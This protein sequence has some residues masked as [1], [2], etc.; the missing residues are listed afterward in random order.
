MYIVKTNPLG[1]TIWTRSYGGSLIDKGNVVI[2]TSD[3]NFVIAGLRNTTTDSTQAYVIKLTSNGILLWDSLYGGIGNEEFNGL[4]EIENDGGYALN[5]STTT[6]VNGD[7]DFYLIKV[8]KD[9]NKQ[10]EYSYG[11]PGEEVFYGIYELPNGNLYNVGY[12]EFFGGGRRFQN[13]LFRSNESNNP[14]N[15]ARL[16]I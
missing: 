1:D 6:S 11:N 12:T 16:F 9:G 3:S 14:F 4:I 7:K 8:D 10:S 5:G 15:G 13:R 2:E